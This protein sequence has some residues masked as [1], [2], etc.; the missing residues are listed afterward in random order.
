MTVG[1]R[2]VTTKGGFPLAQAALVARAMTKA[3]G[4]PEKVLKN[5]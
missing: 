5:Y 1:G 4:H 2:V 3:R